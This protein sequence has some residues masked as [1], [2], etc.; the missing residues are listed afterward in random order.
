MKLY[1]G[2]LTEEI[3]LKVIIGDQSVTKCDG[4]Y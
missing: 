3:Q 2:W 4:K 1:V